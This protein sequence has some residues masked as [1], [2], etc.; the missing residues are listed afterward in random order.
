MHPL[1]FAESEQRVAKTMHHRC[2]TATAFDGF[3]RNCDRPATEK[4]L[5]RGCRI[6]LPRGLWSVGETLGSGLVSRS[7]LEMLGGGRYVAAGIRVAR[8]SLSRL[9][10]EAISFHSAWQACKPRRWK[11]SIRRRY[12]MF[13]KTGSTICCRRR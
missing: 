8:Q 2:I 13:A 7:V 1:L 5:E 12:L 9:W 11:R 10:V 6:K 3:R 4:A